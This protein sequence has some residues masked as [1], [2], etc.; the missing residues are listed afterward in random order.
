[1][2]IM[3]IPPKAIAELFAQ[4]VKH[5]ELPAETVERL[6]DAAEDLAGD[7]EILADGADDAGPASR[8]YGRNS[9]LC[10]MIATAIADTLPADVV[11][12]NPPL[13]AVNVAGHGG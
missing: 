8:I 4:I 3:R 11:P 1:M 9:E 7:F 2:A 5:A 12:M 10:G 6:A 13:V